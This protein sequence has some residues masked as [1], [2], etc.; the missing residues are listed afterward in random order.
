MNINYIY[1]VLGHA[2]LLTG[3][4][5]IVEVPGDYTFISTYK[6]LAKEKACQEFGLNEKETCVLDYKFL[7]EDLTIIKA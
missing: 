6:K 7:G 4:M 5:A 2:S 1:I 3:K